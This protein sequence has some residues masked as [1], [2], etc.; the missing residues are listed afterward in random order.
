VRDRNEVITYWNHAAETLYGWKKE[1]AIAKVVD[2]LLNA[3]FPLPR[4]QVQQIFFA[5][6][7]GRAS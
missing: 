4:E 2:E 1:E 5:T 6:A 3:V 7:S